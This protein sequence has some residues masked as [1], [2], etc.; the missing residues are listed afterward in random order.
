MLIA[1]KKLICYSIEVG[2]CIVSTKS[3]SI[4]AQLIRL[5]NIVELSV[6]GNL[7][8]PC[9]GNICTVNV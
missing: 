5:I 1:K 8:G 4:T 9:K 2:W 7:L 6:P 3:S